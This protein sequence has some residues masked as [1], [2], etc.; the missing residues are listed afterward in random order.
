[1]GSSWPVLSGLIS[2]LWWGRGFSAGS[3]G[4]GY[5]AHVSLN[6][7]WPPFTLNPRA[8][9][10]VGHAD[11]HA[12]IKT[13]R[14]EKTVN[15]ASDWSLRRIRTLPWKGALFLHPPASLWR[16]SCQTHSPRWP[17]VIKAVQPKPERRFV[18]WKAP[19]KSRCEE[20]NGNW[21][22]QAEAH[23]VWETVWNV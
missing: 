7:T 4:S 11:I 2:S 16:L 23:H 18:Y 10:A 9:T 22:S 17:A 5:S 3:A 21:V 1:M 20:Q 13:R 8:K 14:P 12:Y 15:L 19:G 6:Y